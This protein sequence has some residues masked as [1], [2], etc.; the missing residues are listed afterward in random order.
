MRFRVIGIGEYKGECVY[1]EREDVLM[2]NEKIVIDFKKKSF[3]EFFRYGKFL[4]NDRWGRAWISFQFIPANYHLLRRRFAIIT[5]TN[6]KN[7]HLTQFENCLRQVELERRIRRKNYDYVTSIGELSYT[8]L[9]F[10][11]IYDI[12][13]QEAAGLA[14]QFDQGAFFYNDGERIAFINPATKEPLEGFEYR[15]LHHFKEGEIAG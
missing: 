8:L 7:L 3:K 9:H 11:L 2:V 5:A 10:F 1:E 6:P 4:I 15:Y 14:R 13:L 12:P